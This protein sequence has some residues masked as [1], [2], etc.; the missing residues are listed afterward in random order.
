MEAVHNYNYKPVKVS[1]YSLKEDIHFEIN[2]K[3][4]FGKCVCVCRLDIMVDME[5][6]WTREMSVDAYTYALQW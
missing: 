3:H 1:R 6:G 4:T 2:L 5:H